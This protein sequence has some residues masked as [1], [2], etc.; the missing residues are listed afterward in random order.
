ML[1]R[2]LG[3]TGSA[4]GNLLS[5]SFPRVETITLRGMEI[6]PSMGVATALNFQPVG[7]DR[8]ATT[9][10]FVLIADE[11]PAVEQTLKAHG[12]LVTALHHHM[13]GDMPPLYYMHF[14]GVDTPEKIAEALHDALT[15]VHVKPL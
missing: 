4:N 2:I 8:V 3:R 9:G 10:D 11:V 7:A 5:F 6:P 14:F 13:F 1:E 12:M 15:H